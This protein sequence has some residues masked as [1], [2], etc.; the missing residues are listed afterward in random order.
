MTIRFLIKSSFDVVMPRPKAAKTYKVM[1]MGN[2]CVGKT[3]LIRK[4]MY[5]TYNSKEKRSVVVETHT[6]RKDN[7]TFVVY[8]APG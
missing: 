8:D 1:F 3:S 5:N 7:T 6:S 2:T 4:M